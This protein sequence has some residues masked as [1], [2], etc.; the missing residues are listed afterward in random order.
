MPRSK[1]PRRCVQ[2]SG[3]F[4]RRQQVRR[5]AGQRWRLNKREQ[6]GAGI[7]DQVID[8]VQQ[9]VDQAKQASNPSNIDVA[10]RNCVMVDGVPTIVPATGLTLPGPHDI[11]PPCLMVFGVNPH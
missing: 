5:S 4:G 7:A 9:G 1:Y 2:T 11:G 10:N 6:Q 3:T 8:G